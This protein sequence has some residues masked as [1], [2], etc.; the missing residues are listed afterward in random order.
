[1]VTEVTAEVAAIVENAE[2]E[3]KAA[4]ALPEKVVNEIIAEVKAV[5]E[6]VKKARKPKAKK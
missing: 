5:K 6:K 1:M 2:T 4:E 3:L